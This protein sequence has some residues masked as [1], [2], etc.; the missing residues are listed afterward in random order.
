MADARAAK[1]NEEDVTVADHKKAQSQGYA[2]DE[3]S[4]SGGGE[5][6]SS[7]HK[8]IDGDFKPTTTREL[9]DGDEDL[10]DGGNG[11]S[12]TLE[13]GSIVQR[14]DVEYKVYKKRWFGLV[15]LT[16]LNIIVSWDVS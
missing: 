2:L 10:V 6:P 13:G 15:A 7:A 1:T 8:G 9:A 16:L 4:S 3:M 12:G 14:A 11:D 5:R